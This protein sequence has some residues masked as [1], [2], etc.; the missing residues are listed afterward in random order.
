M[1][2]ADWVR[3]A[4]DGALYLASPLIWRRVWRESVPTRPRGERLGLI[5]ARPAGPRLWVHAASVGEV[6]TAA[7]LIRGLLKRHPEAELVVT[8]MTATGAARV[9]SLFGNEVSHHFLPLDFPGAT[10]RFIARLAPTLAIIAETELWPNLIGACARHGVPVLIAN[11][12]LSDGAFRTYRRFATLSR[13]MLRH[14]DWIGA[15]AAADAERFRALGC[16][17]ARV[18][19][20]G[21]LKFDLQVDARLHEESERLRTAWGRRLVWV[22]GSTHPGEEEA[23]LAAHAR[24]CRRYPEALLVLVPRH[25]QRFEAVAE[26]CR[27]RGERVARRSCGEVPDAE[28][29]VLLG[30]TM[31][32]LMHFY[33]AADAAFVGGS[34]VPVGGH[35]LLEPAAVGTPVIS[36]PHLD[37]LR[38]IAAT[39]AEARAR[40]EVTD[41][42][43]LAGALL[44]L[45]DDETAR[46]RLGEAGRAVVD[47]NRGALAKTLDEVSARFDQALA[48]RGP[49]GDEGETQRV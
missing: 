41:A 30:D 10:R 26:L 9:E 33:A 6:V 12:R 40:R 47:A 49:A 27:A 19:V 43:A 17:E 35:N 18:E 11:G 31:G 25:P 24:V 2:R 42:E 3:A 29:R 5:P 22:A 44:A 21:A 13:D 8:T 14:V 45:F 28:T 1:R 36:G 16:P 4:Y 7:P 39:L 32:E 15:K 20:T 23:V 48:G 37:N 34:L 46:R 38:E